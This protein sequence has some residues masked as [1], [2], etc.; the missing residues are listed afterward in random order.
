MSANLRQRSKQGEYV[1]RTIKGMVLTGTQDSSRRENRPASS[2]SDKNEAKPIEIDTRFFIYSAALLADGKHLVSGGQEGKIR[3]WRV[4]DGKEVGT[5]MDAG[6]FVFDI[7]VS[8]D[9]KWVVSAQNHSKVTE[10]K[11]HNDRVRAVHVSPHGSRIATGSDDRT[12][13]VWSLST[14]QRLL[15]PLQHDDLAAVKFSPSGH[16]IATATWERDVR[17]YDSQN[18]GLLVEFPVTVGSWLNQSLAWSTD[19]KRLF[20]FSRDGNIHCLDVSARETLSKWAIHNSDQATC[21]ALGSNDTFIAAFAGSSISFWDT[22]TRQQI[23]PVIEHT[24]D[25]WSMAISTNHDLVAGGPLK[26]TLLRF[27][28]IL[29]SRY[30]HNVGIS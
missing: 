4:E 2:N 8:R 22:T 10:F 24:P 5:P 11:A 9:G 25:N 1:G 27:C 3:R 13:C 19:S 28:D 16:L 21:I 30:F 6:N 18:G 29:P 20:A 17:V 14:A 7:A 12:V 23:G 26:I 15:G